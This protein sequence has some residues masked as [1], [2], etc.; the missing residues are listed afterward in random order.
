MEL[1]LQD[2]AYFLA[3]PAGALSRDGSTMRLLAEEDG[4]LYENK[5]TGTEVQSQLSVAVDVKTSTPAVYLLNDTVVG[6]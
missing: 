3:A 5:W 2:L 4:E 1:K 6:V